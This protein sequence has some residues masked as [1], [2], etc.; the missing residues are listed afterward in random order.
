MS[1]FVPRAYILGVDARRVPEARDLGLLVLPWT[2]NDTTRCKSLIA[3][4]VDGLITD[5]P[6]MAKDVVDAAGLKI[7]AVDFR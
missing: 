5:Y 7:A 4:G 6:D 2:I 1:A 3:L